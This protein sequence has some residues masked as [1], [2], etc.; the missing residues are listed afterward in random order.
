MLAPASDPTASRRDGARA[1]PQPDPARLA[2]VRGHLRLPGHRPGGRA[3]AGAA[4]D[5]RRAG[6]GCHRGAGVP[7][8]LRRHRAGADA[9]PA[10]QPD[11]LA[12][13]GR[14][15]GLVAGGPRNAV[16]AA[17]G[18][19]APPAA[20]GRPGRGRRGGCRLGARGGARGHLA[21]AA[22][23]R[24]AAALCA[25]A[26]GGGRQPLRRAAGGGRWPGAGVADRP[27][28]PNPLAMAGWAGT[29]ATVADAVGGVLHVASLAA[30]LVCL[31]LRFRAAR[32][33]ERQQ[34]RWIAAAPPPPSSGCW[35]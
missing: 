11:R 12:V 29:A 28:H 13:Y 31:V 21:A 30:A 26:A 23:P 14:R 18:P 5:G 22:A 8:E 27:G 7:A 32:G 19:G 20:A 1:G 10:R 25:L 16:G 24:R 35:R 2:A 6:P 4:A 15:P 34:L 33:I 9:A 3:A 17:A